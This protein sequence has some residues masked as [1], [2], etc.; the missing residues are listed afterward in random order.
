MGVGNGMLSVK[1][2]CSNKSS[3][4][5]QSNFI[6]ITRLSQRLGKSGHPQ[7]FLHITEFKIVVSVCLGI[8]RTVSDQ[9]HSSVPTFVAM[10]AVLVD[11][12]TDTAFLLYVTLLE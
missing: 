4:L 7:F 3:F 2:F 12:D 8:E 10:V 6:E 5:C 9:W 1:Y 11:I